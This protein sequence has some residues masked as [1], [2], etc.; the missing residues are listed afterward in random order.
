MAPC[1]EKGPESLPMLPRTQPCPPVLRDTES[2]EPGSPQS[3][4]QQGTFE[5]LASEW[6]P[7]LPWGEARQGTQK[8]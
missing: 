4:P 1:E 5:V 2:Q 8:V 6:Y 3:T 7:V